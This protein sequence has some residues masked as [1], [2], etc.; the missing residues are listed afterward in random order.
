M[1]VK[2]SNPVGRVRSVS[3]EA[4]PSKENGRSDEVQLN[5]VHARMIVAKAEPAIEAV[6]DEFRYGKEPVVPLSSSQRLTP[7]RLASNPSSALILIR[8]E[9]TWS[10]NQLR[11]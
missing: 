10:H 5:A 6:L 2:S 7:S 4:E 1:L 8:L 3:A 9:I 11:V